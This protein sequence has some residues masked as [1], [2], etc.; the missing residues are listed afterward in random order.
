MGTNDGGSA[1]PVFQ[2][3]GIEHHCACGA[4]DMQDGIVDYGMTLRDYLAAAALTMLTRPE[5]TM[6]VDGTGNLPL[7]KIDNFLCEV[8]A[9]GAYKIADAMLAA[10]E[11]KS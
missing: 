11:V 5:Y 6:R 10:R 8:I 1:F 4:V 9:S 2:Q 3:G 7:P